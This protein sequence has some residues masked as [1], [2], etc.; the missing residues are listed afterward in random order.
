MHYDDRE[1]RG[2]FAHHL[3]QM[4]HAFLFEVIE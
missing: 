2:M 1:S 3:L 4:R